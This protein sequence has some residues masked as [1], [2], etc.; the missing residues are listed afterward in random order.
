MHAV[1]PSYFIKVCNII[2]EIS[3]DGVNETKSKAKKK[4]LNFEESED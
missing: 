2:I 3:D 4:H 1:G